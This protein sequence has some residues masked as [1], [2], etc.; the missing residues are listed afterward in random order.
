MQIAVIGGT[1]KLGQE[2]A[3]R[4]A[5]AGHQVMIGTRDVT[6]KTP[7]PMLSYE[8]AA[9]EADW[10][11]LSVPFI[12]LESTAIKIKEAATGKV[13]ISTIVP[14]SP[15]KTATLWLQNYFGKNVTLLSA[16]QHI[17]SK[18]LAASHRLE[19]NLFI[20]GDCLNSVDTLIKIAATIGLEGIHAGPLSYSP[21]IESMTHILFFIMKHSKRKYISFGIVEGEI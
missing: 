8:D 13:V 18:F 7:F 21:I 14:D 9:K 4:L 19:R 20:S 10:I 1:G 2:I 6:T 3:K 12:A 17:P 11:I 16:F 5:K 15:H